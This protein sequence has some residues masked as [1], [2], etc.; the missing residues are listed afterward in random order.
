VKDGVQRECEEM[1]FKDKI[2]P[3]D[4]LFTSLFMFAPIVPIMWLLLAW[5]IGCFGFLTLCFSR[6]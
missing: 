6:G 2:K 5:I 3:L 4:D 1:K